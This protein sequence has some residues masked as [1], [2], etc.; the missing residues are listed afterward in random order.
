MYD[1]GKEFI[2][3]EFI[4]SIIETE[5]GITSKPITSG[6][7]MSNGILEWIHQVIG[8]LVR[9]FNI[10]KPTLTKMTHGR[11]FWLQQRF[12]FSQ[13]PVGEKVIVWAN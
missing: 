3:H 7:P 1:Q 13:Q 9:T 11:A 12:Q 8:N 2:G 10:Q 4:K 6:N 5:Y